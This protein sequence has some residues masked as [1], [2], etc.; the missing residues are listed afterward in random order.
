MK[1]LLC[2]GLLA[3]T[4]APLHAQEGD[5]IAAI[6]PGGMFIKEASLDGEMRKNDVVPRHAVCLQLAKT[7]WLIVYTTHGY[8]V[9]DDERSVL[10]QIRKDAPDGD[11]IKEGFLGKAIHDWRPDGV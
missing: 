6:K 1:R 8:R 5:R 10:Y 4:F 9:V 3:F 11:V 7:R 2:L